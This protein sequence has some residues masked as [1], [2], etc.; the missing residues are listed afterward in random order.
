MS[1]LL[2]ALDLGTT[3]LAGRILDAQGQVLAE[4]KV[5]NPQRALG[6]DIVRRLE[7]AL[8]GE[9]ERLQALLV[10]GIAALLD[11]LLR[12]AG[13]GRES[14]GA[15]AVAANPGVTALFCG[16]D[17]RP[18]LFPPHRPK[19]PGLRSLALPVLQLPVPLVLFPVLSGY[20]GGDLVACLYGLAS[21]TEGTLVIDLGTN[22]EIAIG[23]ADGWLATSVPAGPA[24]EGGEISCGQLATTGAISNVTRVGDRLQ[25]EVIGGGVPT[26]LAGSGLFAVIAVGIE[27]ELIDCSGRI[28]TPAEVDSNLSRYLRPDGRAQAL[29]LYRDAGREIVVTQGDIRAF[30]LAKGAVRAGI[31]ALL[32]RADIP[33]AAVEQVIVTGA[34]G[35]SLDRKSLKS[36][37]ILPAVMVEKAL[38]IPGGALS[39]VQRFLLQDDGCAQLQVLTEKM[40]SYPLS[41]TPAFERAFLAALDF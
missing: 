39:G 23:N 2:L 1:L 37:A 26:G 41:G 28:V 21:V 13:A 6:A 17:V 5:A 7:A 9:G 27:S 19:N 35:L 34:F 4:G 11:D 18:I 33:V 38:F 22:G 29:C 10:D 31:D 36:V 32:A 16:D 30:Q 24:F 8:A 15:V 12:A 25:L 20:V 40:R 14:I 3:T